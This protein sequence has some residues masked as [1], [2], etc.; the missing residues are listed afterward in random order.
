MI[1]GSNLIGFES[2]RNRTKI[3]K[4][5]YSAS[6]SIV[7]FRKK[8]D[9]VQILIRS[10]HTWPI[11]SKSEM[12]RREKRRENWKENVLY[13]YVFNVIDVE[14]LINKFISFIIYT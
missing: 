13:G 12:K 5:I 2:V 1:M 10:Q 6:N 3:L 4:I 11:I 9:A 7:S 8:K 14:I